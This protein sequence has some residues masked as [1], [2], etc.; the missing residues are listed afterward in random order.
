[1]S[2]AAFQT[3]FAR[4]VIDGDFRRTV[5]ADSESA[6]EKD[7]TEKEHR[8]LVA[9]ARQPGIEMTT[10]LYEAWR[11]TKILTLLPRTAALLGPTR[12]AHELRVFW[13]STPATTLYFVD[14]CLA[15]TDFLDGRLAAEPVSYAPDVL[16]F[17]RANLLLRKAAARA[18]HPPVV[19]IVLAHDPSILFEQLAAGAALT[20]VPA[21]E[22]VLEGCLSSDGEEQ[23]HL[24]NARREDMP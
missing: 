20:G 10:T 8:R 16:V 23:W 15:F 11:L 21:G 3:A 9:I 4:L 1:M 12:L 24:V 7:L 2:Q 13:A 17:E 14:E 6:F 18:P 22:F 19:R 5:A